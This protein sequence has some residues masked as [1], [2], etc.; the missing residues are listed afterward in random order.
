MS[1][2]CNKAVLANILSRFSPYI[3]IGALL[4]FIIPGVFIYQSIAE[5][6]YADVDTLLFVSLTLFI[7][8]SFLALLL[9][10]VLSLFHKE[11][12]LILFAKILMFYVFIAGLLFPVS[13]SS[14]LIP[15]KETQIDFTNFALAL[16]CTGIVFLVYS[17]SYK[18]IVIQIFYTFLVMNFG[19]AVSGFVLLSNGEKN[20]DAGVSQVSIFQASSEKNIFVM[21]FDGVTSDSILKVLNNDESLRNQLKGFVF[22]KNVSSSSPSTD[23]SIYAELLGNQNFKEKAETIKEFGAFYKDKLLTNVLDESGVDVSVYGRYANEFKNKGNS[24][25]QGQVLD[26]I[27]PSIVMKEAL[28]VFDMVLVRVFTRRVMHIAGLTKKRMGVLKIV[29]LYVSPTTQLKH[30]DLY[31]KLSR[32][33]GPDWSLSLPLDILAID[34]YIDKLSVTK[35]VVVAHFAH[36]LFSHFPTMVDAACVYKA[37]DVQWYESHQNEAGSDGLASC[38]ISKISAFVDKLKL[39]GI[40]DKSIIVFKS[41]HGKPSNYYP[42][43]DVYSFQIFNDK[44][45]GYSRYT[46]FLMIKG[47]HEDFDPLRIDDSAILLDDLARTLCIHSS[48]VFSCDV[49]PGYDLLDKSLLVPSNASAYY[50]VLREVGSTFLYDDHE[51]LQLIREKEIVSN[52][53]DH[54]VQ[55]ETKTPISCGKAID[56]TSGETFHNGLSDNKTWAW[57]IN[58]NQLQLH[59]NMSGCDHDYMVLL[60][61]EEL[62]AFDH[63]AEVFINGR[64]LDSNYYSSDEGVVWK[65]KLPRKVIGSGNMD[66]TFV[67]KDHFLGNIKLLGLEATTIRNNFLAGHREQ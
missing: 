46:P 44:R 24:F 50:F 66:I 8:Y 45:L 9:H 59:V 38:A 4:F 18:K 28:R 51:P 16:L 53:H 55:K 32:H 41:D 60:E 10:G 35:Q 47:A 54:F 19:F 58:K 37:N 3:V 5:I 21:S 23:A 17:S 15:L 25:R 27:R 36:Y 11:R 30:H 61:T 48:V 67:R 6:S 20:L 40:Y 1:S 43:E 26:E 39:L 64:L 42:K 56:L 7:L 57:W 62:T 22:Y 2:R 34:N 13:M 65:I 12:Y 29:S 31:D 49:Y 52:L 63:H 14:A 33:L